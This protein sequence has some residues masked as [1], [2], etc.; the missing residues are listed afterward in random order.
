[1][2]FLYRETDYLQVLKEFKTPNPSS[3]PFDLV[4]HYRD[5][6]SKL[7]VF[8]MQHVRRS[9]N[10]LARFV[11]KT[12]VKISPR[13]SEKS[14]NLNINSTRKLIKINKYLFFQ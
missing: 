8:S 3:F 12:F 10:G 2:A 14:V 7:D 5:F 4:N 1:M 11:G 6:G 9:C 13:L